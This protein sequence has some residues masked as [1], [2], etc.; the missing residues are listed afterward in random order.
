MF[1]QVV[2]YI[3]FL[4]YVDFLFDNNE[5]TVQYKSQNGKWTF[6]HKKILQHENY[7]T[8]HETNYIYTVVL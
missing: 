4:W 3:I 7:L 5:N 2:M 8:Q 1:L 6:F